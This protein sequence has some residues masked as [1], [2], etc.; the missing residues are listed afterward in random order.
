MD[1]KINK[2]I[3]ELIKMMG[4][5]PE[6]EKLK[7]HIEPDSFKISGKVPFG[8]REVYILLAILAAALGVS[9]EEIFSYM[10]V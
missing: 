3:G 9:Y 6:E 7:I 8:K 1:N 2:D 5:L 4:E 10:G